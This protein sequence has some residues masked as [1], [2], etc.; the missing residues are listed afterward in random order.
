[1]ARMITPSTHTSDIIRFCD[2][3]IASILYL[4]M[5]LIPV[6]FI[7]YTRDQFELPKLTVLRVLTGLMLGLWGVRIVAAG[8][9]AFRR[10]PLDLPVL[11]W[12]A[13]QIV[14]TIVSVSGYVSLMGEYE[15]FRG[16]I[17]VLNYTALFFIATNFI[18]SRRQ[19]DRLLF[20]ILLSGLI[21]T[22]YGIAQFF[23]IDFIRW[24][25]NS[26]APGR[27]FS[28]L[29]NPNFL[30]AYLSMVMPLVIVFFVETKSRFRKALLLFSFIAM[31]WAL[32]GTDSRGG[33]LGLVAAVLVLT[34]FALWKG[35]RILQRRAQ[36]QG[37]PF[38]VL[39]HKAVKQYRSWLALIGMVLLLVVSISATFGRH[40]MARMA[41]TI[42][43]F[44]QA[45]T[46]SRLYIWKPALQIFEHHPVLGTGLD[47]F[48]TVFPR[49]A[50]PE[51]ARVDGANVSSRT[52][53]NEVLQV[54]ACQGLVGLIIVTWLTVMILLQWKKA[55]HRAQDQWRDRLILTGLLGAWTAYSVQ[56]LFSFGVV[57]IDSFYWI[58]L[59]VFMLMMSSKEQQEQSA[60]AQ[61]P[62]PTAWSSSLQPFKPLLMLVMLAAG[63]WLAYGGLRIA[64]ADYD[65]NLGTLFRMQGQQQQSLFY[66][67]QAAA[68]DPWEVK[69]QVYYGLAHEE[70]AKV[71]PET[72]QKLEWIKKAIALYH[73]GQAMNPTNAYYLGNLGRAYGFASSLEPDNPTYYKKSV[74]YFKQ[75][76]H[77]APVTVLFYVN[78]A[79]TYLGRRDETHFFEVLDQLAKFEPK[80]AGKT[81]FSAGNELYNYRLYQAAQQVYQRALSYNP[82][83]VEALFNL[84]VTEA[85]LNQ[86][87]K[88]INTWTRALSLNPDFKP[89]R[90]MLERY[91]HNHSTPPSSVIIP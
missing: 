44:H 48:K 2:K 35:Y 68:A 75:A 34:G 69:Y 80:E 54:L 78:L 5:F 4:T 50:T 52:A 81:A 22:L 36:Q 83:N 60:P 10:T 42:I 11:V 63:G 39:I 77:Y 13:L 46:R 91:R 56:N 33:L 25:P 49:Y 51:F 23:G 86:V 53:H 18:R 84:G 88:A 62:T 12:S 24:N 65:Y 3:A 57:A 17:T 76:I 74:S 47:T 89:A 55:Y 20:T 73:A 6:V 16:L 61:N 15:N 79:M 40:H 28:S 32:L 9:V 43:H 26:I 67:K 31:F 72:R 14:T 59:A 66:F 90:Q 19:I 37:A 27:Y 71:V 85:Q 70:M 7:I 82:E 41:D 64:W 8:R 1:M 58:I 30:A 87:D 38:K 45:I 29:G 21:I